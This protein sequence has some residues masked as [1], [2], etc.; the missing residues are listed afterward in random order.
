[1][2]TGAVERRI[3]DRLSP[4][5]RSDGTEPWP[6]GR[7]LS[8]N[9]LEGLAVGVAGVATVDKTQTARAGE[10]PA[11]E[12]IL[13]PRDGLVVARSVH[14]TADAVGPSEAPVHPKPRGGPSS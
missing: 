1:V 9:E 7:P 4:V 10:P 14:V 13:V 2:V 5:A 8:V 12:P 6:L 11:E 3:R